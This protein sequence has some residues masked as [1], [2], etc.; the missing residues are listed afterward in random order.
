M[1]AI[2]IYVHIPF[3]ASRCGYCD[4]NTYTASELSGGLTQEY[5]HEIL[6]QEVSLAAR[7][8]NQPTVSTIFF[9]GGT[10]T[11]I[12]SA[13]L[14]DMVEFIGQSFSLDEHVEIT[15]EANPDNIDRK[16]FTELKAGG[17]NRIS[18]GMQ[19][20]S[21]QV[22]KVL[23]RT[24]TP[25]AGEAAAHW[26]RDAGFEHINIDLIYGTPGE[27][28]ADVRDSVTAA[29]KS[30]VDHVSAYSLI[31]EDGTALARQVNSGELLAPDDDICADRFEIIDHMLGEAGMQWYEI[32]NWALPGG[33][34]QHNQ[35]YWSG[36]DWWGIGPGAHSH[37]DGTRWWNHKHPSTYARALEGG[38]PQVGLEVLTG[39][40][41]HVET[42]MLGLRTRKGFDLA[43]LT[44]A[45]RN[46][47]VGLA[48][49]GVLDAEALDRGVVRVSNSGRLIADFATNEILG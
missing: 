16:M 2:S 35:V 49:R 14:N 34:G 39:E 21:A 25:G 40:Q 45:E 29:V 13:A 18:L 22:L 7:T 47:C 33:Q 4:F 6:K 20:V 46:R 24:H 17:F 12:G 31:V 3:C 26:A 27:T 28:D 41:R 9:G 43:V 44:E 36:S 10:P 38:S 48:V 37:L 15:A 1:T 23:Q 32:S 30:G 19:S 11:L 8:L 5:F 42:V